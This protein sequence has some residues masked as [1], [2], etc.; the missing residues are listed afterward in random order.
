MSTPTT[1]KNVILV[2]AV[3]LV[4]FIASILAC[5]SSQTAVRGDSEYT[6]TLKD[7]AQVTTEDYVYNT[8]IGIILA[9]E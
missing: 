6:P 7:H 2:Q 8:T 1:Q 4:V 3:T 9:S 5:T